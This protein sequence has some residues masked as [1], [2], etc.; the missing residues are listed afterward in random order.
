MWTFLLKNPWDFS[1][2]GN[3]WESQKNWIPG[4]FLALWVSTLINRSLGCFWFIGCL[5]PAYSFSSSQQKVCYLMA[6]CGLWGFYILQRLMLSIYKHASSTA[7]FP[8]PYFPVGKSS[9][10]LCLRTYFLVWWQWQ[11]KLLPH[12]GHWSNEAYISPF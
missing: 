2:N 9:W 8:L 1:L 3:I 10:F 11:Y 7:H 6:I 4:Y 5:M 12:C